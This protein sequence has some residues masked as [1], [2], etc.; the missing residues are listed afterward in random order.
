SGRRPGSASAV[1]PPAAATASATRDAAVTRYSPGCTTAPLTNTS[2]S[3]GRAGSSGSPTGTGALPA[4]ADGRSD[5]HATTPAVAARTTAAAT[6]NAR[7][8]PSISGFA[9]ANMQTR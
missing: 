6:T 1:I 7:G 8:L 5:R 4:S 9:S 3:A 2:A